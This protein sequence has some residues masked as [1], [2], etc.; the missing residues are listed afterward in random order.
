[1]SP[2]IEVHVSKI[3]LYAEAG[4]AVHD[5]VSGNQ[6]VSRRNYKLTAFYSF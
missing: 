6:L 3:R 1:V 5:N 4:F 2:G